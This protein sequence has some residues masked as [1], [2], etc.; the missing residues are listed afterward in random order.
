MNFYIA[1]TIASITVIASSLG[2]VFL[3][4]MYQ[5]RRQRHAEELRRLEE[6]K[7]KELTMA[8]IRS[9]EAE[10]ERIAG[11]LHDD[12]GA[13][14]ASARLYISLMAKKLGESEI[15]ATSIQLVDESVDKVRAIS[16]KLQPGLISK[17]GLMPALNHY[18]NTIT[19]SGALKIAAEI[20]PDPPTLDTYTELHIY[21]V[22]QEL[23]NNLLKYAKA[24]N[25]WFRVEPGNPYVLILEHNGDGLV[26]DDYTHL[27]GS[28]NGIGL[29]NIDNRLQIIKSSV[30]F[31]RVESDRFR[32]TL[33]IPTS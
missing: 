8:S 21:R 14:L 15:S 1:I 19:K 30:F 11:E 22:I 26:Q 18:F 28:K 3:A 16:H 33:R 24:P 4:V 13:T 10:R 6:E 20:D 27:V 7:Q 32:I 17:L 2:V 29:K 25:M 12:V 9:E 23:V 31:E 5:N